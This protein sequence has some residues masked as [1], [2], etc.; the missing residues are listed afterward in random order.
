MEALA[1]FTYA[2]DHEITLELHT[3]HQAAELYQ[4]VEQNRDFIGKF[5]GW[6]GRVHHQSDM[7]R[8]MQRDLQDMPEE[9]RWSWL[10]RVQGQPA[11]RIGLWVTYPH[12]RECE[13][14]YWLAQPFTGRGILTRAARAVIDYAFSE[15]KMN[16]VLIG[17]H[18][19]NLASAGVAR[20]LS[21]QH[22]FTLRENDRTP[23]GQRDDVILYGMLAEEWRSQSTPFFALDMGEGAHLRL[24]EPRHASEQYHLLQANMDDLRRWF[25]SMQR[26]HTIERERAYIHRMLAAYADGRG[27]LAGIYLHDHVYG[28]ISLSI[29]PRNRSGQLGYWLDRSQRGKGLV[30]RAAR[31][32]TEIG[33]RLYDLNRVYLRAASDNLPSRAVAE[34]I[35]MRQDAIL[36]QEMFLDGRYVDHVVYSVLANEWKAQVL[37]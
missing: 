34:R 24:L 33:F 32:L 6:V 2:V 3:P 9:R 5:L 15:L 19:E 28:A 18:R 4:L 13:L 36:R 20:R 14:N 29:T 17:F 8:M 16:H 22:E 23:Q 27:I 26:P 1:M 12:I 11:G 21:F 25:I 7:L 37:S 30:T 10:I 31:T 35:G